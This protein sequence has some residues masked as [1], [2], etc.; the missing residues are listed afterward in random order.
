[1]WQANFGHA[2]NPRAVPF[3]RDYRFLGA[4]LLMLT[5]AI[6]VMFR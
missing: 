3:W 2:E 4:G 1:M 6:V 5:A